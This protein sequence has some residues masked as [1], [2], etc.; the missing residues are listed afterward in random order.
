MY[1]TCTIIQLNIYYTMYVDYYIWCNNFKVME[2]VKF[3]RKNW[4]YE[5][6]NSTM[7]VSSLKEFLVIFYM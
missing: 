2:V 7:Y 5:L 1:I 3:A 4:I 6:H